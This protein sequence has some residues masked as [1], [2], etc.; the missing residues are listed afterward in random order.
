VGNVTLPGAVDIDAEVPMSFEPSKDGKERTL[1]V[2]TLRDIIRRIYAKIGGRKIPVILYA[3]K[4][5]QGHYQ[6]WFWDTV[7]EILNFVTLFARQGAAYIWHQCRGWGWQQGPMKRLFQASFSSEVGH[8]A[9][10]SKWCSRRNCAFEIEMSPE[11]A[12]LLNFGNSPFILKEGEDKHARQKSIKGVVSHGNIKPNEVGRM[13]VDDLASLG[14]ESNARTVFLGDDDE[15][16]YE[17]DDL[18][19]DVSSMGDDDFDED[20][21][22]EEEKTVA[23]GDD[24]GDEYMED[25]SG[26]DDDSAFS[27]VDDRRKDLDGLN[28]SGRKLRGEAEE[29]A[30]RVRIDAAL[31]NRIEELEE[32]KKQMERQMN[33]KVSALENMMSKLMKQLAAQNAINTGNASNAEGKSDATK[34]ANNEE[35][36]GP[37]AADTGEKEG[38]TSPATGVSGAPAGVK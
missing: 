28:H 9:M 18:D 21:E 30:S 4:T 26:D 11:A 19:D 3:F 22:N 25:A 17:D 38:S 7:P 15:D 34:D 16:K 29:A 36:S 5:P 10:N 14:D 6:L 2:M 32:E 8:S 20:S 12:A 31:C 23:G 35:R 37:G 13:E 24:E 1:K 27:A 33:Q